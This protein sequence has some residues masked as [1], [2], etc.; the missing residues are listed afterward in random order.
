MR[1][2]GLFVTGVTALVVALTTLGCKSAPS[3]RT[4]GLGDV[5]TGPGSLE[6]VRRQLTGTWT[7]TKFEVFDASGQPRE[8]KAQATL[9]YDQYGNMKVT[10]NLLEPLPGQ[11]PEAVQQMLSY[12]GRIQI[13]TAKQEFLLLGQQGTTDPALQNQIGA[14]MRR[15]Y[16][17]TPEQLVL[18]IVDAQSKPASRATFKRAS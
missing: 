5:D 7:L 15:K 10:G 18:T 14:N 4:L 11:P 1:S 13:D 12:T 2:R 3:Q 16:E 9:T 17:I 6:Y 8:V